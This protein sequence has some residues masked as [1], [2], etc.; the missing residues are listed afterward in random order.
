VPPT[1]N[2]DTLVNYEVGLKSFFWN[3]RAS[4]DMAAYEI[5]WK[6]IQLA[7]ATPNGITY[8]A[9][10]GDVASRG[11]EWMASWQATRSLMLGLNASYT[12]SHLKK[13]APSLGGKRGD[14][15][16][17]VPDW[18]AALR[19]EYATDLANQWAAR[20]GLAYGWVGSRNTGFEHS[21]QNFR[22]SAI[23][24][25][26]AFATLTHGSVTFHLYGKNLTNSKDYLGLVMVNNAVT[27][28]PVE[29]QSTRP[30]PRTIGVECDVAF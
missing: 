30:T 16:Q 15:M 7:A 23:G 25:L 21:P 3:G 18:S 26:S 13:D 22:L 6:D 27:G 17:G 24:E 1:V 29:V 4:F 19:A 8:F 11:L 14:T 9:N 10:A 20:L 12:D 5:D 28:A 2:S